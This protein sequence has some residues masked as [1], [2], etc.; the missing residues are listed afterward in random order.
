VTPTTVVRT[1]H[2]AGNQRALLALA[3]D[4]AVDAI[5]ADAW[6]IGGR[7]FA[8]HERPLGGL[9]VLL[10]NRGVRRPREPAVELDDLLEAT[11][12]RCTLILDVRSWWNDSTPE[13]TAALADAPPEAS[14]AL[15]FESWGA[16]DRARAWLPQYPVA[17]SVRREGQLRRY[18][19]ARIADLQGAAVAPDAV[20]LAI[21][22]TLLHDRAEVQA[23]RRF[24]PRIAAWTVD[25]VERARELASWGVDEIVSNELDV[26][27]AL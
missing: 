24:T 27:R 22:H 5:E 6:V 4:D 20:A 7:V 21:R 25:G 19:E 15:T 12:G 9:K 14:I 16:A 10:H 1:L 11:A 13:L 23:L 26:L 8:H 3:A 2:R 17:Y 18:I